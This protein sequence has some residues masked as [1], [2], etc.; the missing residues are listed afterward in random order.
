M[1]CNETTEMSKDSKTKTYSGR[2]RL[3]EI[4]LQQDEPPAKKGTSSAANRRPL[5][6]LTP[7]PVNAKVANRRKFT[8]LRRKTW[9]NLNVTDFDTNML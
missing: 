4:E 1:V 2:K 8:Y 7:K 3:N 5:R 9:D 6:K